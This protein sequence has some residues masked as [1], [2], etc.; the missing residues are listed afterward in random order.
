[1][2]IHIYQPASPVAYAHARAHI[3]TP[4]APTG[5]HTARP[6]RVA[7]G[8]RPWHP[9]TL[10]RAATARV[11]AR[12]AATDA[13]GTRLVAARTAADAC[14]AA[15]RDITMCTGRPRAATMLPG[16][17]AI[18]MSFCPNIAAHHP[19]GQHL[20][21]PPAAHTRTR[22]PHPL[23]AAARCAERQS[24]RAPRG[25]GSTAAHVCD[26]RACGPSASVCAPVAFP[27]CL[28]PLLPPRSAGVPSP[29][30]K[31]SD[32]GFFLAFFYFKG[33]AFKAHPFKLLNRAIP[34]QEAQQGE[35][36]QTRRA[37]G[38]G[39]GAVARGGVVDCS[40]S[41]GPAVYPAAQRCRRCAVS[42]HFHQTAANRRLRRRRAGGC[43]RGAPAPA[44]ERRSVGGQLCRAHRLCGR[45][46]GG[47]CPAVPA[48]PLALSQ[49][50]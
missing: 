43:L 20:P 9:R 28:R 12:P 48:V 4:C 13:G 2:C 30:R 26:T 44:V 10:R 1:M 38:V 24:A 7:G 14:F 42:R 25:H 46:D 50:A 18:P 45:A 11:A 15:S 40:A 34:H 31:W 37:Q 3:T 22:P 29:Y 27:P 47:P 35:D 23:A 32:V 49:L 16:A 19:R 36:E 39:R 8:P 33:K 17:D 21:L 5:R 41:R 6:A